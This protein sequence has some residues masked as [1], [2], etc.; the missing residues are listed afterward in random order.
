MPMGFE[1]VVHTFCIEFLGDGILSRACSYTLIQQP[2]KLH[3]DK[4]IRLWHLVCVGRLN[5]KNGP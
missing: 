1:I 4:A 2:I 5:L 3:L